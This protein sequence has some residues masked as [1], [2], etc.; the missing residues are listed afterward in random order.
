MQDFD[1]RGCVTM[2]DWLKVYN[3]ADVIP[4]IKAINKTS[5]QYYPD[6]IDMLKDAVSIPGRSMTLVLN[7]SLRIKQSSKPPLFTPGQPCLHK[8]TE[9]E[10]NPK[11]GCKGCMKM[12]N[13]CTQCAKHKLYE[14]LKM[15]MAG[16]PSIV[17]CQ[18]H[19]SG[20]SRICNDAK[21]CA[22][23][24]GFDAIR[25]TYTA[26][27]KRCLAARSSMWRLTNLMIQRSYATKS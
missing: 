26:L 27:D 14:L 24:A 3:E 4:F 11:R 8:C 7:K 9:C 16:G 2:M 23:G 15:G 18:Y 6:E 5:K 12:Q 1:E 20:K 21:A 22:K 25:F 10:A 13:D 19:E 17:F